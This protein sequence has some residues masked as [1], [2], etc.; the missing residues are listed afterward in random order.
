VGG[1]GQGQHFAGNLKSGIGNVQSGSISGVNVGMVQSGS[2]SGVN[3]GMVQSG[4]SSGVNVGGC[5]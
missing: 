2:S 1:G 3:V 4:S 5:N